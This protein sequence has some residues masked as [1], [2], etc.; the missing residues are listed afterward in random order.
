M[1]Q[2]LQFRRRLRSTP[3]SIVTCAPAPKD[4]RTGIDRIGKDMMQGVVDRK[5]PL[6]RPFACPRGQSQAGRSVQGSSIHGLAARLYVLK[7]TGP[8]LSSAGRDSAIQDDE[9]PSTNKVKVKT[10]HASISRN[11][12]NSEERRPVRNPQ[13]SDRSWPWVLAGP[14]PRSGR[15]S[16][17][18]P[19]KMPSVPSVTAVSCQGQWLLRDP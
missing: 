7:N 3:T 5:S 18:P 17:A 15:P 11:G 16:A 4:V 6:Q 19:A 9:R 12:C 2:S 1:S 10:S 8:P 13:L 14:P